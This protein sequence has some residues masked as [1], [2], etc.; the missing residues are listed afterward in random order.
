MITSLVNN[1]VST[2]AQLAKEVAFSYGEYSI[3]NLSEILK[4]HDI[5]VT[6]REFDLVGAQL[7]TVIARVAKALNCD[8]VTFDKDAAFDRV[9]EK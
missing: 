3:G 6:K 8:T 7:V 2:P 1:N 9:K 5:K 4:Q